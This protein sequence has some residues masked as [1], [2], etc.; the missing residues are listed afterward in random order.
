MKAEDARFAVLKALSASLGRHG[1]DL[2]QALKDELDIKNP[3]ELYKVIRAMKAEG[4]LR[5][6]SVDRNAGRNREILE[7]S[8]AGLEAYYQRVVDSA[9][10]FIDLITET[11]IRRLGE[12]LVKRLTTLDG[13]DV[14]RSARIVLVDLAIPIERQLQVIN[15]VSK[16]FDET[17]VFYIKKPRKR[18]GALVS[19]KSSPNITF[20]DENMSLKPGTVDLAWLLGP[21]L[22][23]TFQLDAGITSLLRPA[24][25]LLAI[26]LKESLR[27]V[28]PRVVAG[29]QDLFTTL[30][31]EPV[32][33]KLVDSLS[34][35]FLSEMFYG[36]LVLDVD[37][38][39]MLDRRFTRVDQLV[40]DPEARVPFF[41]IFV[42]R[43]LKAADTGG[44]A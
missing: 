34:R 23:S 39:G 19:P 22:E 18:S 31:D 17:P 36:D 21:I 37:I 16:Y 27:L 43:G 35:L 29:I 42:A 33:G 28:S 38:R 2:Y 40:L 5:V 12:E 41:D 14:L 30:F 6:A 32:S 25:T 11:S 8:T 20:L 9:M 4:L 13:G 7:L 44:G 3:S 1:Y 24:G 26:T 10:S 15:Q